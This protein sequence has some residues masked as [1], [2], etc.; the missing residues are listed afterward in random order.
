M[1]DSRFLILAS[2][3]PDALASLLARPLGPDALAALRVRPAGEVAQRAHPVNP[4]SLAEV[5]TGKAPRTRAELEAA[6]GMPLEKILAVGG[7]LD[8]PTLRDLIVPKPA[9]APLRM[10]VRLDGSL[11]VSSAEAPS[12]KSAIERP[13]DPLGPG[14]Y[15]PDADHRLATQ[16]WQALGLTTGDASAPSI[17]RSIPCRTWLGWDDTIRRNVVSGVGVP[18]ANVGRVVEIITARC[19]ASTS[20]SLRGTRS[21]DV[22][23]AAM[24]IAD[25]V[26]PTMTCNE[27]F[28]A[29]AR[30][31]PDLVPPA[32]SF[33]EMKTE[34]YMQW[35]SAWLDLAPRPTRTFI[36]GPVAWLRLGEYAASPVSVLDARQGAVG[37]CFLIASLAGAAW[38]RPQVLATRSWRGT[39]APAGSIVFADPRSG[40]LV[41]H[42]VTMSDDVPIAINPSGLCDSPRPYCHANQLNQNWPALYEK[43][44]RVW[45]A[46]RDNPTMSINGS[47]SGSLYVLASTVH[48]AILIAGGNGRAFIEWRGGRAPTF[49][50]VASTILSATGRNPPQEQVWSFLSNHCDPEGKVRS[51]LIAGTIPIEWSPAVSIVRSHFYTV[52]GVDRSRRLVYLR[53]PWG[54]LS[55]GP[56]VLQAGVWKGLRL[57]LDD[58]VGVVPM[59]MFYDNFSLVS[60]N[61]YGSPVDGDGGLLGSFDTRDEPILES[62]GIRVRE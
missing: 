23:L 59:A 15:T 40:S 42:V 38:V 2:Y 55:P 56:S 12:L 1:K 54:R 14:H 6:F 62:V 48:P 7:P 31:N 10:G 32:V 60:G 47:M 19:A 45:T 61:W 34:L 41:D 29:V 18:A 28:A 43:A 58:G 27:Q 50:G 16:A 21:G 52:L 20:R 51:I 39:P 57:G 17:S 26:W 46:G 8:A 13:M 35:I 53:N 5:N 37:N 30:I 3:G 4:F 24:G 49:S 11:A 25:S 36:E 33:D 44:M 9:G 22:I